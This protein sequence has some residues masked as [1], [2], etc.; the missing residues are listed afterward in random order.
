MIESLRSKIQTGFVV[1]LFVAIAG[2]AVVMQR[3][4]LEAELLG[5]D[6]YAL[7]IASRIQ[8]PSDLLGTFTEVMMDG[9][10]AD[11]D[12]YRPVANLFLAADYA[13]WGL[14]PFGFQL[15]SLFVWGATILLLQLLV[16]RV[17]G[18]EAWVGASV[19]ALFYGFHSAS[20]SVLPY[21]ARR[22]ETLVLL[23]SAGALC[24][25]PR[26][27]D[28]AG[29]RTY[30]LVGFLA[31]LAM[32]SKEAGI[33]VVGLIF[34]HQFFAA[35]QRGIRP[36]VWAGIRAATPAVVLSALFLA[37]RVVVIGGVGGYYEA[38]EQS[39]LANL[40]LWVPEYLMTTMTSEGFA[41]PGL[42]RLVPVASMA[43]LAAVALRILGLR[44]RQDGDDLQQM[45]AL[46]ALG[47]TWLIG[48]VLLAC[49]SLHFTTSYLLGMCFAMALAIGALAESAMV[50]MRRGGRSHSWQ[51]L[52]TLVVVLVVC[53][54]ALRGSPAVRRYPEMARASRIQRQLLSALALRIESSSPHDYI[55]VKLPRNVPVTSI[56]VDSFWMISHWGL[57]AWLELSLP[58]HRYKV[59]LARSDGVYDENFAAVVLS[60][61]QG[62]AY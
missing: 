31:V 48:Q 23:F 40:L 56:G 29:I 3:P 9:R 50:V 33:L 54:L 51:G 49:A 61:T 22:P 10:L 43:A 45:T 7:I 39:T 27:P 37:L 17:L 41:T 8:S 55:D 59:G 62:P 44:L 12:F 38:T 1:A 21:A 34:V 24:L 19:A 58:E 16:I 35:S 11:G 2:G 25:L 26:D 28:R 5:Y 15:T 32:A 60:P 52:V 4:V 57:Q 36:A 6:V 46:L 47:V 20:L 14:E 53:L 42:D 13:I 18:R 30:V